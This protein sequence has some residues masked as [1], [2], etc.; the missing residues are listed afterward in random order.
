MT[1]VFQ[2]TRTHQGMHQ[3]FPS[4]IKNALQQE[5]PGGKSHIKMIPPGRELSIKNN[6][7]ERVR[8]SSVLFLLFPK[9][10]EIFTCLT[11]RTSSMK[12]HPGQISFP[13][14]KIEPGENSQTTALREAEEEVGISPDKVSILGRLSELYIPVSRFSISPFVGWIDHEPEFILN[15]DESEK[16]ILFPVEQFAK[17]QVIDFIELETVTGPL[18]VPYYPFDG[19][20]VWGA[21]AM[22]MAEFFDLVS[23]KN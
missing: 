13:G 3:D 8:Y 7:K 16:L 23:P 1:T 12:Y 20:I 18:E 14:G 9:G 21:T 5:L 2:N 15:T 11:K 22:I 17:E 10:G 6:D 4:Y 19:E